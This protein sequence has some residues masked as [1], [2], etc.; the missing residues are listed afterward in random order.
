[1]HK[2]HIVFRSQGGLDFDINYKYYKGYEDHEGPNGPHRN[3][4]VDLML[5]CD[6]QNELFVVFGD[7]EE[8]AIEEIAKRL[9]RNT[10]YFEKK[11]KRVPCKNGLY[12]KED[13]VRKLMGGKLY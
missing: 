5:K 7:K 6:M 8:F 4:A 13:I 1:M 2:H 11:F 10:R 9:G 12:V 3:R